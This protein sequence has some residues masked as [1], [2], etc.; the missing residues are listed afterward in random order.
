MDQTKDTQ[1]R[2][3]PSKEDIINMLSEQIE[4]KTLQVKLQALNAEFAQQRLEELKALAIAA[5][6]TNPR[7]QSDAYAGGVPH[8]I[9][10]EDLDENPDLAE[11]G[12][13][14]GDEI[15]I[16]MGEEAPVKEKPAPSAEKRTLK[17]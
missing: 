14:V 17:K 2:E 4:V 13:K 5:Q 8:T 9:T 3:M 6:I 7:P 16:P 10:Q 11:Q 1:Q 15:L 12:L